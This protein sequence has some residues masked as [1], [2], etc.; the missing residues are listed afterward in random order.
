MA[1]GEAKSVRLQVA[2]A[3]G[4]DIGTGMARL[5]STALEQLGLCEGDIIEVVGKRISAVIALPPY[6]EDDWLNIIRLDGYS[7]LIR[8]RT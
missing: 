5:S 4:Q 2:G 6:P 8:I 1:E 7:E 3:K